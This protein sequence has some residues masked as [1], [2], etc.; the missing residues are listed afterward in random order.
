MSDEANMAFDPHDYESVKVLGTGTYASVFL[1]QR[2]DNHQLCALKLLPNKSQ[3]R[4]QH[5]AR[6]IEIF[7]RIS[8]PC[9]L[10]LV[11]YRLPSETIPSAAL[12]TEYMPNGSLFELF[13]KERQGQSPPQ[14]DATAKTKCVFGMAAGIAHLHSL[15]IMHRDLKS[16][17]ILLDE[18]FEIRICDF[19]L[20]KILE[21]ED[22]NGNTQNIGTP[23]YMAPELF[24]NEPYGYSIDVYAFSILVYETITG[25]GPFADITDP[26]ILGQKVVSGD[27]PIIPETVNDGYRNLL[28]SCWARDARHR[29]DFPSIIQELRKD[30]FILPGA[31]RDAVLQYREKVFPPDPGQPQVT[32]DMLLALQNYFKVRVD[33]LESFADVKMSEFG[34]H[35]SELERETATMREQM[36]QMQGQMMGMLESMRQMM[37]QSRLVESE[38]REMKVNLELMRSENE[39]LKAE[40]TRMK[41]EEAEMKEELQ[42]HSKRLDAHQVDFKNTALHLQSLHDNANALMKRTNKTKKQVA[43]IVRRFSSMEDDATP[44]RRMSGFV[45][46]E[47]HED[48]EPSNKRRRTVSIPVGSRRHAEIE[49][50]MNGNPFEGIFSRL[51]VINGDDDLSDILTITGTSLDDIAA[52][53][54]PGIVTPGAIDSWWS[55]TSNNGWI[56]F[57]FG[58]RKVMLRKYSLQSGQ[59]GRTHLR[60]WCMEGY[61]GSQWVTLDEVTDDEK[62]NGSGAFATYKCKNDVRQY[63][64]S[65]R[66]RQTGPSHAGSGYGFSLHC[67]EFFGM[68]HM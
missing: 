24:T 56:L 23:L 19:G 68:V 41:T 3:Q 43:K 67:I 36:A 53:N 11:A 2:R 54:L 55:E 5:L 31:D 16:E 20:S 57:D 48:L 7:K 34:Q 64:T 10:R 58:S 29:P 17:N 25:I 52:A 44:K 14:W 59:L 28:E 66:L 62:L 42:K 21:G 12:L 33:N 30:E 15:R 22:A 65:I 32:Y 26:M 40:L 63:F 37:E 39:R 61:D 6:E 13:E 60:S 51:R 4:P 35:K 18:N 46:S 45:E 27:R 47:T 8:H 50:K 49:C 38:N 1:V 9:L